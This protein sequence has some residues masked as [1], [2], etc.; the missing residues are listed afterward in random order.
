M[1]L[2]WTYAVVSSWTISVKCLNCL[3]MYCNRAS[4][5]LLSSCCTT[6]NIDSNIFVE[7]MESKITRGHNFTLVEKQK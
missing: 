3:I 5:E 2:L 6:T 1:L 4:F 7:I